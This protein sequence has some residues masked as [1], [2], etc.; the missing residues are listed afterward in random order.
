MKTTI[1]LPDALARAA[2]AQAAS[3]GTT[4]RALIERALLHELQRRKGPKPYHPRTDLVFFGSGLT[5]EAT[6]MT[7]SQIREASSRDT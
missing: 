6:A 5:E 4:L 7:W 3:E 1:E 2:K